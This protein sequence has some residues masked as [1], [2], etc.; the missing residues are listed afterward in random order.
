VQAS[1]FAVQSD[2]AREFG[3]DVQVIVAPVGVIVGSVRPR[4][5]RW[6]D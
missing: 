1:N 4:P 2:P 6:L 5:P 3:L